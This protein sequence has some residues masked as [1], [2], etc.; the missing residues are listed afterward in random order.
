MIAL[1]AEMAV[2]PAPDCS[3]GRDSCIGVGQGG[4]LL[5][6]MVEVAVWSRC[7]VCV[8]GVTR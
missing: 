7:T 8:C 4:A 3:D 5:A 1:M 6:L 2:G